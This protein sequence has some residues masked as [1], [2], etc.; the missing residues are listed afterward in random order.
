MSKD[1]IDRAIFSH[2]K[3]RH[4]EPRASLASASETNVEEIALTLY[5][6]M[7][8]K[9]LSHQTILDVIG[10]LVVLAIGLEAE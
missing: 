2:R 9:G 8:E 3:R 10:T 1:S 6:L 7:R 4:G 5:V